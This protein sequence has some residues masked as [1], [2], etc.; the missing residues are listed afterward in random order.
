MVVYRESERPCCP[1]CGEP[2]HRPPDVV[3][4]REGDFYKWAC[5][6]GAVGAYDVTGNNL[7]EAL[8]EV[9]VFAYDDDWEKALNME[10]DKDYEIRYLDCY[11]RG[12]HRALRGHMTYRSGLA[13]FVFVK[14]KRLKHLH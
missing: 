11:K 13:A 5:S 1:F 10:A 6:C 2:F 8:M 4:K 14:R 7:G 12:E 3:P 9:I